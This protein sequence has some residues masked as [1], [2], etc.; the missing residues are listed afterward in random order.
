[1]K[2]WIRSDNKSKFTRILK[3]NTENVDLQRLSV[4][5][6]HRRMEEEQ[7]REL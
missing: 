1:M 4:A 3:Q 6:Q 5:A 2:T 7:Q